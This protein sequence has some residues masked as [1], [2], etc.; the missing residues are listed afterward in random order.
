MAADH[1]ASFRRRYRDLPFNIL[2]SSHVRMQGSTISFMQTDREG[3]E[4]LSTVFDGK[5]TN[6]KIKAQIPLV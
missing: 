5:P 4:T 2:E 3:A 6:G 1:G